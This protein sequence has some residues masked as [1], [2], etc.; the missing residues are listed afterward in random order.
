MS[1]FFHF[2]N[3]YAANFFLEKLG[4]TLIQKSS[5]VVQFKVDDLTTLNIDDNLSWIRAS[6]DD[7]TFVWL[8][9]GALFLVSFPLYLDQTSLSDLNGDVSFQLADMNSGFISL[10]PRVGYLFYFVLGNLEN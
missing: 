4:V 2:A 10:E 3:V 1:I 6:F 5:L 8:P 9:L 7:L